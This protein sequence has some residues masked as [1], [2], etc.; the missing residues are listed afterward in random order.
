MRR[1]VQPW[2]YGW[3]CTRAPCPDLV[4]SGSSGRV[5]CAVAN[6][7]PSMLLASSHPHDD[8]TI[9]VRGGQIVLRPMDRLCHL[10][11]LSEA[12]VDGLI[13]V[14]PAGSSGCQSM[15]DTALPLWAIAQALSWEHGWPPC[16]A[17][18][19]KNNNNFRNHEEIGVRKN[20]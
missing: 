8:L 12:L 20:K 3:A 4:E 1:S 10:P 19:E 15:L 14:R 13:C 16:D 11:V 18:C 5:E 6:P 7:V 2:A 9:K 17:D